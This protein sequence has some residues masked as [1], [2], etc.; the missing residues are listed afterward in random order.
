[1]RRLFLV[2]LFAL[3]LMMF[4]S[5]TSSVQA[6]GRGYGDWG[7]GTYYPSHRGAPMWSYYTGD[8]GYA[9]VPPVRRYAPTYYAPR[10][11]YSAPPFIYQNGGS[12]DVGR[13][14]VRW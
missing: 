13:I 9:H 3:A 2:I 5:I 10:R 1:M 11:Y 12:V 6:Q 8:Y 7:G 14:H 4:L